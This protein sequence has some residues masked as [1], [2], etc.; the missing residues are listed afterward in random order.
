MKQMLP[1]TITVHAGRK[2]GHLQGIAMDTARE[3]MY[4]SF[5]TCLLKTDLTGRVVGSVNG[6]VGHL[7]CIAWN[8]QDSRVYGSLEFKQ[9]AIGRGILQNLG[10]TGKV[11]DGFYLVRFDPE[12]IT[13]MDMDAEKDGV[14]EAVFL[15]EVYEDYAAAGHRHGCSGIDG[16][17]FAPDPAGSGKTCAFVAYGVY[18]DVTR[19]DNDYQ[20][21]LQYDPAE[22][23]A[24]A[25]PLDQNHMHR[26]GPESPMAKL[27]VYTGNTTYGIQNL[28]YDPH[29]GAMAAAVYPGEKPQFEN[30]PMF[31]IDA[32]QKPQEKPLR[33]CGMTGLTLPLTDLCGSPADGEIVGSWFDL[34]S[35]GMISLGDG[36]FYMARPFRDDIGDGGIIALYHLDRENRTFTVVE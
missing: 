22:L 33:G 9:D 16:V 19:A 7:G 14:M 30:F 24:Y 34:G 10:H 29:T 28:E 20:V 25:A 17:T 12:K 32:R 23:D 35:T 8:A 27:F 36:R 4:F 15:R 31:F 13:R 1:K 6:L 26:C 5:T 2:T 11:Q 3:Y 21:I 18:G